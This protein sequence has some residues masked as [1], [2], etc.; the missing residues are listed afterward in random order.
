VRCGVA[1]QKELA[2]RNSAVPE[3][4]KKLFSIGLNVGD[5]V[6]EAERIYGDGVNIAARVE[7]LR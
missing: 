7:S 3:S 1:V 4:R 5:I 2:E 6:V